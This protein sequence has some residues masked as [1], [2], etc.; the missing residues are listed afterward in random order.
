MDVALG[1]YRC[2]G[3]EHESQGSSHGMLRQNPDCRRRKVKGTYRE[4]GQKLGRNE[5]WWG[6]R[7][8]DLG[9]KVAGFLFR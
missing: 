8:T 7:T 5:V 4:H 3:P 1:D 2:S 6:E 9:W